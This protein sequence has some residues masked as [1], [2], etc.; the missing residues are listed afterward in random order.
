MGLIQ[1]LQTDPTLLIIAAGLLGLMVG[2]FLNVVVH[3]LPIMMERAWHRESTEYLKLAAEPAGEQ[4]AFN[5]VRPA[6]RCP[7]CHAPV[8]PWQNIPLISYLILGAKCANCKTP[9]SLRYPIVEGLTAILSVLVVW[10]FGFS[11]QAGMALILTWALISLSLIDID[12]QL[13]PDSISLPL[14]WLGL[15]L[16]I[17]KVFTDSHS[18]IIGAISGYLSLW[19]V[20]QVFKSLTGKEGMGFG[21]FKLLSMLGAWMGWQFLPVIIL[22][23]SFVGALVGTIL[24][25]TGKH[26]RSAPIPFGPYLSAAGWIVLLWGERFLQW[27][28]QIIG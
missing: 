4:E 11:F 3:R 8:R 24:I 21:D 23:S 28:G 7:K 15:A 22:F 16:S 20:Y 6:S 9:I 19:L 17:P 27:Y 5:L 12:H 26:S 1:F 10:H 18:A 13:L 14:L 25:L 2:S